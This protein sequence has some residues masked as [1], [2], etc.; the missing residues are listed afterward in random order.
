MQSSA[1]EGNAASSFIAKPN[2][3]IRYTASG[4]DEFV[5]APASY[6][7]RG[8]GAT[9]RYS[10]SDS[11]F[12]RILL[13]AT[14]YGLCWLGLAAPDD[15]L[16]GE[17]RGDYSAADFD[18]NDAALMPLVAAILDFVQG[19][20]PDLDLPVDIRA[21]PFE[22]AVWHQL[23]LIPRGST[24]SYGAIAKRLGKPSASRPVGHANGANPLAMVI[25][26]HRAIGSDGS[27]TGYR[28]GLEVKRRLLE[29]ERALIQSPLKLRPNNSG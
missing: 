14:A 24:R 18:R 12:G 17:L 19:K 29:H 5:I 11:P 28:W 13:A 7:P 2:G 23:C 26:C 25:P 1:I 10:I 8:S 4:K 15:L 20:R 3:W 16:E 21:T 27:L 22:A 9:I 6:G